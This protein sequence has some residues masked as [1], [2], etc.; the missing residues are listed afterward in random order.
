MALDRCPSQRFFFFTTTFLVS[1]GEEGLPSPVSSFASTIG[2]REWAGYQPDP[3]SS[4]GSCSN[5]SPP[6]ADQHRNEERG[7]GSSL[8]TSSTDDNEGWDGYSWGSASPAQV[9]PQTKCPRVP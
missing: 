6:H 2:N 4:N 5:S 1:Q 9:S 7:E 3:D 8:S